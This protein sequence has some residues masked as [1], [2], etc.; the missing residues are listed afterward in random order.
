MQRLQR[1]SRSVAVAVLLLA[2]LGVGPCEPPGE[3]VSN[4]ADVEWGT[5][6]DA[7]V[8][9]L[10]GGLAAINTAPT[11]TIAR[12]VG[13]PPSRNTYP[14]AT[15][16]RITSILVVMSPLVVQ[17]R[18]VMNATN[19]LPA[20]VAQPNPAWLYTEVLGTATIP[21][22]ANIDIPITLD[23][24]AMQPAWGLM[25]SDGEHTLTLVL[26]RVS[27]GTA[28]VN[29]AGVLVTTDVSGRTGLVGAQYVT[30]WE[31]MRGTGGLECPK[32]GRWIARTEAVM[33]G[34]TKQLVAPEAWD[35]PEPRT[36]PRG[37]RERAREWED[38]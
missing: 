16:F 17:V 24:E 32:T 26:E 34:Y 29:Q 28:L 37:W 4:Y 35:P 36:P 30:D 23:A 2:L 33:D 15:T 7:G 11:A 13:L 21:M 38:S 27:G 19:P 18:A 5:R 31:R 22:G 14:S 8:V 9:A 1:R 10:G 12:I 20:S 6:T 3:G 25:G